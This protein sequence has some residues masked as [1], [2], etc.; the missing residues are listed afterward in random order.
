MVALIETGRAVVDDAESLIT[1]VVGSKRLPDGR[2]AMILDAGVNLMFTAYWYHHECQP[3][4]LIEGVAEETVLYGPL[5]MNIDVMR[6]S[7]WLPPLSVG[8]SLVFNPVGA[9]NNTQWQQFIEYR[10]AIVMV[11]E[12]GDVSEVRT[13]DTLQTMLHQERLPDRLARPYPQG[14]PD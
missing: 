6:S 2:K 4:R 7:V 13:P 10:P 5:C 11:H 8:D 12:N 1:S 9:Y 14:L 3:T